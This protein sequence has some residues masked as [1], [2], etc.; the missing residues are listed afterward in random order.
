VAETTLLR[1]SAIVRNTAGK[2]DPQLSGQ[3]KTV[4]VNMNAGGAQS[5]QGGGSQLAQ[6]QA[7]A[8]KGVTILP[9]KGGTRTFTTGGLPNQGAKPNVLVFQKDQRAAASA[10]ALTADQL[11]LCRHLADKYLGELRAAVGEAQ[12]DEATTNNIKLAEATIAA[13]DG[14]MAALTAA[15]AAVA[16]APPRA[17][18]AG[19]RSVQAAATAPR[20]VTRSPLPPLAVKMDGNVAIV[21]DLAPSESA[22]QQ[23]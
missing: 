12:P 13:V 7:Q 9:P 14:T 19:S 10:A 4:H 11:L 1:S 15:A 6:Q 23:G 2:Q 16:A 3:H 18:A 20:R 8:N 22:P 21:E 17:V 5:I